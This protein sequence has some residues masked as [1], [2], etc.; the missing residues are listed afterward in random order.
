MV[1]HCFARFQDI[2]WANPDTDVT[3]YAGLVYDLNICLPQFDGIH[4]T[5]SD[6]G[7]AKITF[8]IFNKN[9]SDL[10]FQVG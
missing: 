6:T 4:R 7:A 9:Q 3:I 1:H 2:N 10:V 8:I 5:D